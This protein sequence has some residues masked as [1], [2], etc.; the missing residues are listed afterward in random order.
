[1]HWDCRP[2]EAGFM[3]LD[4]YDLTQDKKYLAAAKRVAGAYRDAQLPSGTWPWAARPKTGGGDG[5]RPPALQ[6]WFLDRLASQ[7]GIH[8][9]EE[10]AD[11]A[12][13]W[14]M[15]NEVEP[16]DLRAAYDDA[17]PR[18]FGNQGAMHGSDVA[19]CL[20][21]RA[22]RDPRH[23]A[24]GEEILRFVED[25]FVSWEDGGKV[26]ERDGFGSFVGFTGGGVTEAYWRAFK[27]TGKPIYLAK[28]LAIANALV[29]GLVSHGGYGWWSESGFRAAVNVL[30]FDAFLKENGLEGYR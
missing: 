14:L 15:A 3:Y 7:Y 29:P 6:I 1:M 12:F 22:D 23:I 17:A 5:E 24:Q 4:L 16:F 30:E 13:R 28:C 26:R 9:Y 19:T 20:F 8:D 25:Q 2:G 21:N 11:R 27:A 18:P 10:T